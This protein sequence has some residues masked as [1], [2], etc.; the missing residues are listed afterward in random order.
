M[1][2]ENSK[3]VKL[4]DELNRLYGFIKQGG[5][6]SFNSD[7]KDVER[8]KKFIEENYNALNIGILGFVVELVRSHPEADFEFV[9][10]E[11]GVAINFTYKVQGQVCFDEN[12]K[13][14]EQGSQLKNENLA[15]RASE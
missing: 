15:E 4:A 14:I 1:K 13:T 8:A 11:N 7:N 3:L 6:F 12:G 2:K 5:D 10:A 9:P